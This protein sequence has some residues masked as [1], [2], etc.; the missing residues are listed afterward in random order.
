M[1]WQ[2][3]PKEPTPEMIEHA[4]KRVDE[5]RYMV[6]RGY[7]DEDAMII[8]YRAMLA[9]APSLLE[10]E[11]RREAQ[12]GMMEG[13]MTPDIPL[14]PDEELLFGIRVI[15]HP[16][17]PDRFV[18]LPFGAYGGVLLGNSVAQVLRDAAQC[19]EN[20]PSHFGSE[21]SVPPPETTS[22]DK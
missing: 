5:P 16:E 6:T 13:K 20:L 18:G 8:C 1:E 19:Y 10:K 3:V 7:I 17:W 9:V 22:T 14:R 4:K 15:K 12:E 21:G 2:V 11:G